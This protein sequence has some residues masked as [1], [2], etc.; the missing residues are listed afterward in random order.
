MSDC[1]HV[2]D[3]SIKILPR[4]LLPPPSTRQVLTLLSIAC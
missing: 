1:A 2:R 3:V 4:D